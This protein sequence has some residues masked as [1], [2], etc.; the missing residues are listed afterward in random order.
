MEIDLGT[1]LRQSYVRNLKVKNTVLKYWPTKTVDGVEVFDKMYMWQGGVPADT[2]HKEI[3]KLLGTSV[4]ELQAKSWDHV[5]SAWF[6]LKPYHITAPTL[7]DQDVATYVNNNSVLDEEYEVKM[8]YTQEFAG[9]VVGSANKV[10]DQHIIDMIE[11]GYSSLY[12]PAVVAPTD[13]ELNIRVKATPVYAN[14][15]ITYNETVN[16]CTFVSIMDTSNVL[17]TSTTTIVSKTVKEVSSRSTY[18]NRGYRS[19][20]QNR[21]YTVSAIISYKYKRIVD[22]NDPGVAALVTLVN[23]KALAL[24]ADPYSFY[25]QVEALLREYNPVLPGELATAYSSSPIYQNFDGTANIRKDAAS[26][27]KPADFSKMLAKSV[28]T[29]Y[30]QERCHGWKCFVSVILMIVVIV[31]AIVLA[32]PSG[33]TSVAFASAASAALF[34]GELSLYLTVGTLLIGFTAQYLSKNGQYGMAVSFGSSIVIL[35]KLA[36]VVG[37][38]A[39][40]TGIYA[41]WQ[42]LSSAASKEA[43]AQFLK[44]QGTKNV[45]KMTVTQMQDALRSTSA[46]LGSNGLVAPSL[47]NY[48][49]AGF[50]VVKGSTG[51]VF[52]NFSKAPGASMNKIVG[53]LNKGMQIYTKYINPVKQPPAGQP[54]GDTTPPTSIQDIAWK[55]AEF[56]DYVFLDMNARMDQIPADLTSR[57]LMRETL[58]RYYE[59]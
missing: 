19:N 14:S 37:Y 59:A 57:G 55:Q 10:S 8:Q 4:E 41:L 12:D 40:V 3:Y 16:P 28:D 2:A 36:E 31:V 29:D 43:S 48:V 13:T 53:W 27:L 52:S 50:Q 25:K 34:F 47:L 5:V 38:V 51:S 33:G 56:D 39:T 11:G 15:M 17:F 9:D 23:D 21:K 6:Y 1:P 18:N 20:N 44:D 32:V 7:S 46:S 22:A 26:E 58:S 30:E 49:S 42:N 24:P 45:D 54:Q 35:G